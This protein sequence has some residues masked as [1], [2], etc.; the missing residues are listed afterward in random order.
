MKTAIAIVSI[1]L[2]PCGILYLK[3]KHDRKI[4]ARQRV[5]AEACCPYFVDCSGGKCHGVYYSS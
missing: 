1:I 4:E 3:K 5:A 2:I